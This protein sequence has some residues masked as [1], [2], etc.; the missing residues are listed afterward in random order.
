MKTEHF[1]EEIVYQWQKTWSEKK[2]AELIAACGGDYVL[3]YFLKYL[4]KQGKILEC[5]CGLGQWVI[6]LSRLGYQ[7]A[8]LEIV[9]DC[10][11]TCK[12]IFPE[13]DVRVGDVRRMPF[14]ENFFSGYISLGVV[15]HMIEG[16]ESTLQELRRVLKPGGVAILTVPAFNYFMRAWYPIRKLLVDLVRYNRWV[17]KILG[18]SECSGEIRNFQ[19]KLQEIRKQLR[20]DFWPIIGTDPVL[21]PLFIEYK[22][23]KDQIREMLE[24][25]DLEILESVPLWHP[26]IFRDIFGD[27]FFK[28]NKQNLSSNTPQ[29]NL[30]GRWLRE[31]FVRVSPHCFNYVYLYVVRSKK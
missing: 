9:P 7:M 12:K 25:L 1:T 2:L 18:K 4:P 24:P 31:F 30:L 3:P 29:L 28:K 5:G 11:Q 22:C 13:A 6:Y 8:G 17:R 26:Y 23:K 21:G 15:E 19:E 20:P 27:S 16:P 10:V 14:P